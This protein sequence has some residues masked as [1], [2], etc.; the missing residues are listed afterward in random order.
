MEG[1]QNSQNNLEKRNKVSELT[2]PAFETHSKAV[3]NDDSAYWHKIDR[4]INGNKLR[5]QK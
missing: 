1:T 4:Q 5:I 2:L 3:S